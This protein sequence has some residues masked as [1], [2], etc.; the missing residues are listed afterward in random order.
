MT[1]PVRGFLLGTGLNG[2]VHLVVAL[3]VPCSP[4]QDVDM[5]VGDRLSGCWTVLHAGHM[6]HGHSAKQKA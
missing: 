4:G 3:E 6:H 1:A 2:V 5:D